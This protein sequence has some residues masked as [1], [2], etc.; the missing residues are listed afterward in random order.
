MPKDHEFPTKVCLHILD[1]LRLLA[2][3]IE[4]SHTKFSKDGNNIFEAVLH[5]DESWDLK[6]LL[7]RRPS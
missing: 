4:I 7:T 2:P 5:A 6:I 1:R 3:I